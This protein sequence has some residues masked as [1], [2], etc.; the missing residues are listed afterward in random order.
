M[1][2]VIRK[3][4]NVTELEILFKRIGGKGVDVKKYAGK[5]RAKGSPLTLQR[6]LRDEW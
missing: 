6:K 3:K 2:T 5:V 4:P 1:E